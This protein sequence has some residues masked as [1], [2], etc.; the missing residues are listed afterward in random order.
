MEM[1]YIHC[2]EHIEHVDT[3]KFAPVQREYLCR[4]KGSKSTR[5][6]GCSKDIYESKP[7]CVNDDCLEILLRDQAKALNTDSRQMRWH[8]LVIK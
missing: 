8:P 7:G 4:W 3:S 5:N 1:L 2:K 6:A